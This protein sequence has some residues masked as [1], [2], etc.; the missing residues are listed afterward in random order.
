MGIYIQSLNNLSNFIVFA[1]MKL[2]LTFVE[3]SEM[4]SIMEKNASNTAIL[5]LNYNLGGL[6]KNV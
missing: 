1:L 6:R 3:D 2:F 5:A 4:Q